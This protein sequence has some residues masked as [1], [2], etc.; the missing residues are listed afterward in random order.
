MKKPRQPSKP[1]TP[2]M[3]SKEV[4]LRD[5]RGSLYDLIDDNMSISDLIKK[6]TKLNDEKTFIDYDRYDY[7]PSEIDFYTVK[8]VPNPHLDYETKKYYKDRQ[9]YDKK[10]DIYN[11]ELKKYEEDIKLYNEWE[12][13]TQKE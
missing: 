2:Q 5:Y 10:M 12:K 3:P 7:E 8:R 13:S 6:L 1:T 9:S 4:D 11:E